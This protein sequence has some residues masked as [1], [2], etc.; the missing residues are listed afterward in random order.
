MAE[1]PANKLVS[2]PPRDPDRCLKFQLRHPNPFSGGK[3]RQLMRGVEYK[4]NIVERGLL[5][6]GSLF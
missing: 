3:G 1:Y 5:H 4:L 2:W 6:R